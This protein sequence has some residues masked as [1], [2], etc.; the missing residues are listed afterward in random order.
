MEFVHKFKYLLDWYLISKNQKLSEEFIREFQDRLDWYLISKNQK[1]SEEFIRVFKDQV[2]WTEISRCQ[3]LS[4]E[5]IRE[6]QDRVDWTEI[7]FYQKL[8]EEFIREF[9][10]RVDWTGISFYQKLSEE[11]IREFQDRV[12]WT[13]ISKCQKLSEEFIREF[14]DRVVIET[15]YKSHHDIRSLEEKRI[16]VSSYAK[17]YSLRFENDILYA[18]RNHNHRGN[19]MY[20]ISFRYSPGNNYRDWHCDLD[21]ENEN[22]FGLGIW[23]EG[24]TPVQV[25]VE[26]W[27]C[28]VTNNKG[29]A[30]VWAFSM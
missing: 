13:E 3:K 17:Q 30:R 19:G 29:K 24:N 20:N 22:S 25:R 27:G 11:F 4:E 23:P 14:K 28:R 10:D 7:S 16:E 21:P 6:F 1:L 18:F 26:D 15:Q 8:S 2:N 12:N 5:F 9:K